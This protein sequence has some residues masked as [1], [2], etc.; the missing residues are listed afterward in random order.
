MARIKKLKGD[1]SSDEFK[2]A[3]E[4]ARRSMISFDE[5]R[6]TLTHMALLSL[7]NANRIQ[8]IVSQN[9]DGLFLKTGIP[10]KYIS[11]LHGNFF[12]SECNHCAARFIRNTA[13]K[14]MC[15]RVDPSPEATCKRKGRPCRG[16]LRDT[17]LDW[18]DELPYQESDLAEKYSRRADLSIALGTTLQIQPAGK[19]PFLAKKR[20]NGKSVIVNLQ[21]TKFDE[22][23]NLIIHEKVDNVM[24]LLC[25]ELSVEIQSYDPQRDPTKCNPNLTTEWIR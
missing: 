21:S 15:L 20:P 4:E 5:A 17:I 10:R 25:K 9:V 24:T 3:E 14:T 23:A 7:I 2:C 6:P 12:L 18:E 16:Q 1:E 22:K 8:Y 19:L 11:E 13:S